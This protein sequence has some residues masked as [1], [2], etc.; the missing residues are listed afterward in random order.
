M[1]SSECPLVCSMVVLCGSRSQRTPHHEYIYLQEETK[2]DFHTY[3]APRFLIRI[4]PNLLQRCPP[5]RGVYIPNLM[6]ITSAVF[7]IQAPKVL[8]KILC[9]FLFAHLKKLLTNPCTN[10]SANPISGVMNNCSHKTRSIY[11]HAYRV[12]CFEK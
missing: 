12:N 2:L 11:Y 3:V 8:F 4:Q 10:F 5:G 1:Q 7:V 6:Q 9:F